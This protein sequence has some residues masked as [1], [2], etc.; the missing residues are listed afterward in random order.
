MMSKIVIGFRTK[1]DP[2]PS[3]VQYF[4]KA[5]GVARFSYNWAL[6][7]NQRLYEEYK[8]DPVKNPYPNQCL[9]RRNFNAIKKKDYPW[10][11][12]VT[13]C[14][15]QYAIIDFDKALHNF[16]SNP[17][18]FN[19]PTFRKKFVNDSFRMSGDDV[20]VEGSRIRIPKLGWVRMHEALRFQGAKILFATISRSAG[21]WFIGFQLE[22]KD[23]SHLKK[24]EN[25]GRVGIDLGIKAMVTLSDGHVFY[26]PKPLKKYLQTLKRL[27]RKLSKCKKGGSKRAKLGKRI[28]RLH[29]RIADIRKDALHKVTSYI[30]A[31][32]STVVIED[33]NVQGMLK[34][35][36]LALSISD[37]GFG[38]FRRQLEYKVA[39]R[40]GELIV[41]DRW[42]PSSKLCRFCHGKNDELTL[43]DR[44]WT[45]P[46]CGR[47]IDDRDL[48]AALNLCRYPESNWGSS[49]A[50]VHEDSS[51]SYPDLA[52]SA[53]A[54]QHG[55]LTDIETPGG[56]DVHEEAALPKG[57]P[58][59]TV[60]QRLGKETDHF[61]SAMVEQKWSDFQ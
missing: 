29:R 24:G 16:L 45:C 2:T 3:Q 43:A 12:E 31:N 39:Q 8:K 6:E 59:A 20:V 28:A 18:H 26:A 44:S 60:F 23:L 42:Y 58:E 50:S 37:V 7:E 49:S 21:D 5:C 53:V 15:P 56:G 10:V 54:N 27:Q 19:Y 36:K 32:Y 17:G 25:H 40:G 57:S 55:E 47:R 4:A 52:L 11:T 34:N 41:A 33:L 51:E 38:E 61:C 1:L 35:H 9:L 14:A 48:N 46:H 22:L 30:A 13:K